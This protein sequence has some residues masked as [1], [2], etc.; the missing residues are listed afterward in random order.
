MGAN[1]AFRD[2]DAI[3]VAVAYLAQAQEGAS[4][5]PP[6]ETIRVFDDLV[7]S[8]RNPVSQP[9]ARDASI[10]PGAAYNPQVIVGGAGVGKTHLL[11][12]VGNLLAAGPGAVV[13][14]LNAQDFSEELIEAI[15]RD[16]VAAWRARYRR[17]TALL[18]DD[19]QLLAHRERTQEELYLLFNHLLDRGAQLAFTASGEPGAIAGLEERLAS[20]LAGGLVVH[21]PP[22]E[23]EVRQA[24]IE[25]LLG[26]RYDRVDAELASYLAARPAESVRA[27]QALV[28]RIE[29][30]A[31]ARHGEPDVALARDILEGSAPRAPRPAP[32]VRTSGVSGS[33]FRS[34]EKVVWE[35][36]DLGERLLEEWR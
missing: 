13:A 35:W 30:A 7:E 19:V 18:L 14:C 34:P 21:L 16:R 32:G 8:D 22:P 17:V 27:V 23:R 11:H 26:A 6:P 31:D 36:P 29:A 3:E 33:G 25:R 20:R 5:P 15:E 1:A 28:Q 10:R 2:P 9:S 12:A 4:P 24:V